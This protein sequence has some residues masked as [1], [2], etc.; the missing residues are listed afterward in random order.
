MVQE[1]REFISRGNV[2]DLAIAVVIGAAFGRIVSSLVEDI[3]MPPIGLLLEGVD[4]SQLFINLSGTSYDSL[5]AAQ[6]AGAPTINYGLF[7]NNV[8][9]F[10][11]ISLVV[12][13]VLKQFN[14]FKQTPPEPPSEPKLT[15][16]E[17][18]LME[19]RDSLRDADRR[20]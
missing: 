10:F 2:V 14:R 18:L 15:T 3:I 6:A 5:A 17:K 19:I 20:R 12:F 4:F 8:A 11:I 9:S 16:S 1:F 13:I 7:L